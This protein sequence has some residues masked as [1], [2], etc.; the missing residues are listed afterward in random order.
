MIHVR[1]P[2]PAVAGFGDRG[3]DHEKKTV[4]GFKK[5]QMVRK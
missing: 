3:G 2:E 4:G 1:S 5:L